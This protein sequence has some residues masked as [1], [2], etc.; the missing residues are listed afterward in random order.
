MTY[1]IALISI[2]LGSIAQ[3]LLKKGMNLVNLNDTILI[4]LKKIILN[5]Y[6]ISGITCYILSLLFWLYVLSKLE[7]SKAYPMVSLG[8]V[9]TIILGYL[10][11]N[12]N[13]S[14]NKI[15]GVILIIIGVIYITK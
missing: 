3:L 9:F 12:E 4:I 7:L 15:I 5:G 1:I 10:L 6:I 13:I 11:L 2:F 14:V 8:Y